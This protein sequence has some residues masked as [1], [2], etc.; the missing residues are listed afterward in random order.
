MSTPDIVRVRHVMQQQFDIVDG[1]ATVEEAL[2]NMKHPMTRCLI[3]D[4]R[5]VDDEF[6]LLLLSDIARKVLALDRAM[7]RVNVYEVMEKPI[8]SVDPDMDIKY[9]ARLFDRFKISRSPVVDQGE[10]VGVV[11]FT[12]MV[13]K[14]MRQKAS[15]ESPAT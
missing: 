9:C 13:I 5:H 11:G 14:G 1:M 10:V 6:G 2:A 3:V 15:L 12:D 7:E 4:K 8:I